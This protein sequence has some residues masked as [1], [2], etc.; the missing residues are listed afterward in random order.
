MNLIVY[1]PY[2]GQAQSSCL[3]IQFAI[4]STEISVPQR[5]GMTTAVTAKEF[6]VLYAH[7]NSC[8]PMS[9]LLQSVLWIQDGL[10][11]SRTH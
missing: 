11:L 1:L 7:L 9:V 3:H 6:G 2:V 8:E 5:Q 10:E 4:A